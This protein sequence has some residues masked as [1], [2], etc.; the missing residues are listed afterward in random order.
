[1]VEEIM[2]TGHLMLQLAA[3]LVRIPSINL[4]YQSS[5]TVQASLPQGLVSC[6]NPT[7]HEEK[8]LVT[9]EQFLGCAKSVVLI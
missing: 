7:S 9:I 3:T 6:P 8:C 4:P 5:A 1:L 2:H